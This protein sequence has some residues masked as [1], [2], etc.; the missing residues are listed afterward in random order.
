MKK[1][2]R[3]RPTIETLE[4]R[5]CPAVTASA[6][7]AAVNH[8]LLT[9][10]GTATAT[11]AVKETAPGAV[12]IDDGSQI[13]YG[14]KGVNP[15]LTGVNGIRLNL[16]G[17]NTVTVDLGGNTLAGN[18]TANLGDGTNALTVE[19]GT[20]A[21]NLAVHGSSGADAVTLG[22]GAGK[23]PLKVTHDTSL[24][25]G[26]Q[27]GDTVTLN[28]GST[29]AD[30]EAGT[31]GVTLA[32]GSTV[33]GQAVFFGDKAGISVA[34]GG[35]VGTNL[36]V[37][38]GLWKGNQSGPSSLTVGAKAVIGGDLTFLNAW[39][40]AH[41]STLTTAAG[42]NIG[43]D[44]QYS[45][46]GLGDTVMLGGRVGTSGHGGLVDLQMRGGNTKVTFASGSLITG[47]AQVAFGRGNNSLSLA[48]TVGTGDDTHKA[49]TITAGNGANQLDFLG[50]GKVNGGASVHLGSGKN[51]LDLHGGFAI[52]GPLTATA[53]KTGGI[54]ASTLILSTFLESDLSVK[55]FVIIP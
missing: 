43:G 27:A 7:T 23:T 37:F 48:G 26:G 4:D 42:S 33:S 40:N 20:V 2:N 39:S 19:D 49:L 14:A 13:L 46:T 54:P 12:E 9:V 21:G 36:L 6:V 29:L 22:D 52:S 1:L 35:K 25:L 16:T 18:L 55:G 50:A 28:K 17:A 45:A 51:T 24:D 31:A 3:A 32:A 30:L 53:Q 34:V 5:W 11:L 8:G 15:G 38:G 41:P 47:E 10:T 44:L